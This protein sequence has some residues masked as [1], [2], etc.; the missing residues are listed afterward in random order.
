MEEHRTTQERHDDTTAAYHAD[1]ADHCLVVTQ[2]IEIDEVGN[3]KE[4][5]DEDD[6]PVP[7]E[8]CGV[9]T[10]WIPQHQQ[11]DAHHKELIDVVP[12]LDGHL[13]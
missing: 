2:C 9:M 10:M 4:D 3:R 8:G 7:M 13:V 12:R 11:H 5:R 6:A 1:N